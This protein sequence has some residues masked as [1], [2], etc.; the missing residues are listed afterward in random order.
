M[1]LKEYQYGVCGVFCEMCPSG[2]G[3]IA[4]LA[5]NLLK[6]I[7]GSYKWPE[8]DVDFSFED[9]RKGLEWLTHETCPTC[10]QIKEPW[11]EV[12][13]CEKARE[14]K[15]CLRCKEFLNCP[16]TEYHRDR[17][18]FVVDHYHRVKEVGL[19]THLKEEREKAQS[20]IT[21]HDIRKW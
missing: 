2:T 6:L 20:G 10:Q 11:C 7:K 4:Q 3:K 12:L 5:T 8:K 9:L 1:T 15:S 18:P 19:E 16:S 21:L 14:L 17:Y 13:K